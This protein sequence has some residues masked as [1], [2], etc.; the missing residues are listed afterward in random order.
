MKGKLTGKQRFL[1]DKQREIVVSYYLMEDQEKGTY[2]VAV[3]KRQEGSD[4]VE[5]DAV[6]RLS[7]SMQLADRVVQSLIRNKVTP[8]SFAESLDEIM[9]RE[10][11]N[12]QS[13]I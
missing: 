8:V 1:D 10:E 12:D 11:K 5:W 9:I 7:T 13:E 6:P 3:E 4:I 2:G